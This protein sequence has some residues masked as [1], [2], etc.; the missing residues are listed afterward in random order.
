ME[1]RQSRRHP[2]LHHRIGI[3]KKRPHLG[4]HREPTRPAQGHGRRASAKAEL[5]LETANHV[6]IGP[7]VGHGHLGQGT[8]DFFNHRIVNDERKIIQKGLGG[9]GGPARRQK[10][11]RRPDQDRIPRPLLPIPDRQESGQRLQTAGLRTKGGQRCR[12]CRKHRCVRSARER[13]QAPL[14]TP[15][16]FRIGIL[17]RLPEA[18]RRGRTNGHQLSRRLLPLG[19]RLVAQLANQCRNPLKP[20]L[21]RRQLA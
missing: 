2:L 17:G 18:R 7:A 8:L 13:L 1:L 5:V 14:S 16:N 21:P 12:H 11:H 10:A 4:R 6:R 19:K 9:A 15:A 3:L 20:A